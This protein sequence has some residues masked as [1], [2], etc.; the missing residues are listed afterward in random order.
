M[1][2]VYLAI[3][4]KGLQQAL[5][6]ASVSGAVIWCGADAMTEQEFGAHSGLSLTRFPSR[7]QVSLKTSLQAQLKRY[8]NIIPTRLF[9]S[10]QNT[11]R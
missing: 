11:E 8:E 10:N 7:W 1:S 2:T 3:S 4:A 6:T 5:L 9:G